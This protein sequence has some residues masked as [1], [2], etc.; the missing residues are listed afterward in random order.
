M[1]AVRILAIAA[2]AVTTVACGG[3]G[4]KQASQVEEKVPEVTVTV[5]S[6]RDVDQFSTYTSSVEAFAV[7]NIAPQSG[8]RIQKINAE[9]GDFVKAGDVLAEMDRVNL[10]QAEL[11]MRNNGTELERLRG[12][13]DVGGLSKS[14]LDNAELAYEVSK[15]SYENLLENAVLRSPITGV[16]SA[17]NYD[18]GDMYGMGQP[19]FTVQ[20]IVP[21]KLNIGISE[22]DYTK[23]KKGDSVTLTVDAFPD[24]TFRGSVNRLDPTIDFLTHT[25]NVEILVQ[26]GDQRLRPGMYARVTVM[27]ETRHSIVIPDTAVIKQS[28]SGERYVYV[29]NDDNTVSFR[30]VTLGRRMESEQEILSGLDE[31]ETVVI[32]G[33]AAIRDGVKVK[34]ITRASAGVSESED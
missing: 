33:Q 4:R 30:V 16:V 24:R 9:V 11:Q 1:K 6:S 21:V 26:N 14:D 27:L 2:V 28:G 8:G 34:V 18:R 13:Y 5:T 15:S 12:L 22:G 7:N 31:G 3:S 20:Q 32:S 29:L 17:R 10:V 19:I 25:C 23:V